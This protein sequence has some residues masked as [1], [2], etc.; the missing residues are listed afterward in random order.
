MTW[1]FVFSQGNFQMMSFDQADTP[2]I[3][4]EA[5]NSYSHPSQVKQKTAKGVSAK[6]SIAEG[7][8]FCF[9]D[10]V[11][12][13]IPFFPWGSLQFSC[14][15]GP[16]DDHWESTQWCWQGTEQLWTANGGSFP[17]HNLPSTGLDTEQT[18]EENREGQS[19]PHT[20]SISLCG[21]ACA[22]AAK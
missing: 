9:S 12:V 11:Q 3:C 2:I 18:R 19:K 16:Q 10:L 7:F 1:S 17:S 8:F 6:H 22:S 20:V 14:M 4:T 15:Q 5:S 13:V 21:R